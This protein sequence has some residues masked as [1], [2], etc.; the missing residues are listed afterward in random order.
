MMWADIIEHYVNGYTLTND[1]DYGTKDGEPESDFIHKTRE[2]LLL[3]GFGFL[4]VI[5]V[6][7]ATLCCI[8]RFNSSSMS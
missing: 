2:W 7:I 1:L 3:F 5:I 4:T 8:I 6:L